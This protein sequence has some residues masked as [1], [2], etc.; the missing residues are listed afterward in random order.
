MP[1]HD[2]TRVDSGRFHDFHQTWTITTCN[3]LNSGVLPKD[4]F[5]MMA[6]R[7][8]L[9]A[10]GL[11]IATAQSRAQITPRSDP[12]VYA[13]KADRITVRHGY[14]KI[15]AVVEIVSPGNKHSLGEFRIFVEK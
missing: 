12:E 3:A 6:G 8:D 10:D 9:D 13:G 11:A 5:A 1:I 4:Y 14:G 7:F 2:W 15:V